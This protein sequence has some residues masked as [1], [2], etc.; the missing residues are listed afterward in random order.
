MRGGAATPEVEPDPLLVVGEVAAPAALGEV[1]D[2]EEMEA[3][4]G[5]EATVTG[6]GKGIGL[7]GCVLILPFVE[8]PV[9]DAP[10]VDAGWVLVVVC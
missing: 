2:E 7:V 5:E 8:A 4:R 1:G 6:G 10:P 9:I 3:E